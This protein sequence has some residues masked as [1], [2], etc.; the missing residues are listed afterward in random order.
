[1]IKVIKCI[2]LQLVLSIISKT[3]HGYKQFSQQQSSYCCTGWLMESQIIIIIIGG[4]KQA[5]TTA[6]AIQF[7]ILTYFFILW[8][9]SAHNALK[10]FFFLQ[11]SNPFMIF[12]C[13]DIQLLFY[14]VNYLKQFFWSDILVAITVVS[15]YQV[16]CS[17][18]ARNT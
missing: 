1:M 12:K 11:I 13:L 8:S 9:M 4:L 7:F 2:L 3:H 10:G 17:I 14:I 16:P 5:M 18:S 6:M 15:V